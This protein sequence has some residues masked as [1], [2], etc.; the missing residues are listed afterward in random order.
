MQID[1]DVVSLQ[2]LHEHNVTHGDL[3]PSN[4]MLDPRTGVVKI[5][6]LGASRRFALLS[7]RERNNRSAVEEQDRLLL[8]TPRC[9]TRLEPHHCEGLGSLTGSPYYMA[10]EILIQATRYTD[11][12]GRSRSVLED[13]EHDYRR[14]LSRH[15]WPLFH[16]GLNDLRRGW[17]IRADVWSWAC[18]VL[19]LLLRTLPEERRPSTSTISPFDFSFSKHREEMLDPLYEKSPQENNVPR[20]HQWCRALPL[21]I[22]KVTLEPMKLPVEA[23]KCSDWLQLTL[24]KALRHQDRRPTADDICHFLESSAQRKA[25]TTINDDGMETLESSN[26]TPALSADSSSTNASSEGEG[27]V[28]SSESRSIRNAV[29][30]ADVD[31]SSQTSALMCGFDMVPRQPVLLDKET[32]QTTTERMGSVPFMHQVG[33]AGLPRLPSPC[34]LPRSEMPKSASLSY[35]LTGTSLSPAHGRNSSAPIATFSGTFSKI[36]NSATLQAERRD[37]FSA[38]PSRSRPSTGSKAGSIRQSTLFSS[39]RD[40]HEKFRFRVG[41]PIAKHESAPVQVQPVTS[42][43][44]LYCRLFPWLNS[45]TTATTRCSDT[46]R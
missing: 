13:Y 15:E 18:T 35:Q 2:F 40:M 5:I 11:V 30:T 37:D 12:T 45:P 4:L 20:F 6:D 9:T 21:L 24:K 46:A 19:A 32:R 29:C 44:R 16:I 33:H 3:K 7:N 8:D 31:T 41:S 17:G 22:V 10:P 14:V 42:P 28:S 1:Q 39:F 38:S 27:A 25:Q 43:K 36:R 26:S 34:R 23:N